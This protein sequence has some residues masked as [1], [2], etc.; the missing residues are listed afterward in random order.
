MRNVGMVNFPSA[1]PHPAP[2][3][4]GRAVGTAKNPINPPFGT[5][6]NEGQ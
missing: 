3:G 1:K 4:A 6:T 5:F 2:T